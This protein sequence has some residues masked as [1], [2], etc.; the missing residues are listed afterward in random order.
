M[1]KNIDFLSEVED[2]ESKKIRIKPIKFKTIE[3]QGIQAGI[4][5]LQRLQRQTKLAIKKLSQIKL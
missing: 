3:L 4:Q 1:R 5:H 2:R